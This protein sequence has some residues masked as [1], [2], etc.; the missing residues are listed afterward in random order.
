[1]RGDTA[2]LLVQLVISSLLTPFLFP[3]MLKLVAGAVISLDT[4]DMMVMLMK[5][6]FIPFVLSLLLRKFGPSIIEETKH[7]YGG[8]SVLLIT[9]LLLGIVAKGSPTIKGRLLESLP[10]IGLAFLL[11]LFLIASGYFPFL[12]LEKEKRICLA[13]GNL[14]MNVGLTLVI[15]SQYFSADVVLFCLVYELPANTL[16]VAMQRLFAEKKSGTG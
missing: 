13:L 14:F 5:L 11:G 8:I 6:I 2:F 1:M 4:M 9:I 10:E 7:R 12:F 15:A 16:P 3:L